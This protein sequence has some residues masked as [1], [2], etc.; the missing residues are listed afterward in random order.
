MYVA[1]G[2]P[3]KLFCLLPIGG[4]PS[5]IPVGW[6]GRRGV[7]ACRAVTDHARSGFLCPVLFSHDTTLD[8]R[9]PALGHAEQR[10]LTCWMR[11]SGTSLAMPSGMLGQRTCDPWVYTIIVLFA[12]QAHTL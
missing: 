6:E 2:W 4:T 1:G 5:T 3:R 12:F 9:I 7:C 8:A 10:H 11:S